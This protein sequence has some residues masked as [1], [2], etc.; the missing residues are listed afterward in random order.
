M[1]SNTHKVLTAYDLATFLSQFEKALQ[2]GYSLNIGQMQGY[3][4]HSNGF[5]TVTLVKKSTEIKE[6]KQDPVKESVA[7]KPQEPTQE[8][9]DTQ[10]KP[11]KAKTE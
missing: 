5:F 9:Q 10:K 3:P 4:F 6:E 1:N 2:E 11:R 7:E 8:T